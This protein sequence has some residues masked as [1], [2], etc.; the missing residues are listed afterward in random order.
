MKNGLN[1][2]INKFN[3]GIVGVIILAILIVIAIYFF[4]SSRKETK[5]VDEKKTE[6]ARVNNIN[7]DQA[8]LQKKL[9]QAKNFYEYKNQN[10]SNMS[11]L[12]KDVMENLTDENLINQYAEKNKITVSETEVLRRY[13]LIIEGYNNNNNITSGDTAFL[14]K[15]NE[16]YGTDKTIYLEQVKND[17]LK[18]KVQME[19]KMPIKDW[20]LA[21]RSK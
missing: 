21:Q 7:I 15:I 9:D 10:I 11:S 2:K 19:V 6:P 16:M 13:D 17:I 8:G 18:E 3:L 1:K 20:L 4:A 12:E 14:A 5:L